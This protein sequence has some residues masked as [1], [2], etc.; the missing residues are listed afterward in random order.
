MNCSA[1]KRI[2]FQI[3]SKRRSSPGIFQAVASLLLVLI[4]NFLIIGTTYTATLARTTV[5]DSEKR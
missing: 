4:R 1:P 3:Y 2:L 5:Q